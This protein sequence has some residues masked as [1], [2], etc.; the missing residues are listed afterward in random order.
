MKRLIAWSTGVVALA[1]LAAACSTGQAGS[2]GPAPT[3]PSLTPPPA[4]PS[5]SPKPT[6]SPSPSPHPSGGQTFTYQLWFELNGKLFV[7]K[8]TSLF[9]P[10]VGRFALTALFGGPL[11]SERAAGLGTVVA[12]GTRVL[13]LNIVGGVATV[14]LS[15]EFRPSGGDVPALAVAEVVYTITQFSNVKLVVIRVNGVDLFET[16]QTRAG[17]T[18]DLPAILVESP[19]IGATVSNPVT[20]SGTANVFEATVSLR[21]LDANGNEIARTF[22]Q[23]TCGTGCR[24]TFS[25]AVPYRVSTEQKGTI[26]VYEVSAK[27]GAPINVVRIPVT[28]TP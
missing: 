3:G 7:T 13:G 2:L 27:D 20:V 1:V 25:A 22:T 19:L 16:A 14:D 8:R 26:E 15:S 24:G 21:I 23:A 18:A 11:P 9:T 28:L 12:P 10:G 5:A 4:S 17:Y 6:K